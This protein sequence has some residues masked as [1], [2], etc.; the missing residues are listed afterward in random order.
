[1]NSAEKKVLNVAVALFLVGATVKVLP[2]GLPSIDQMD[3]LTAEKVSHSR[4]V[5]KVNN[6]VE[7]SMEPPSLEEVSLVKN[8]DKNASPKR[9]RSKKKQKVVHLPIHI[10]RA[11]VDEL[12][13]LKGV[14]PK[15]AEKIIEVRDRNG[16]FSGPQD[17]QKVPGIGKKKAEGILQG[18]IFD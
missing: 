8:V 15:L 5:D 9:K 2:W 7:I 13:A 10:N 11:G 3:E 18:V 12:C 1:M 17:L 16:G 14:G 4:I 6:G